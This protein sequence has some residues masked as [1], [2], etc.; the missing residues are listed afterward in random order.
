MD[1]IVNAKTFPNALLCLLLTFWQLPLPVDGRSS[2]NIWHEGVRITIGVLR[3]GD[4]ESFI[5]IGG[6]RV[7]DVRAQSWLGQTTAKVHVYGNG[8][9]E[10]MRYSVW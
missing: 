6:F 9:A 1:N 3:V 5:L 8:Q 10:A 2:R 7:S 4:C